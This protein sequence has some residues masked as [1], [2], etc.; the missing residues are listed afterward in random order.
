MYI[1]GSSWN[2]CLDGGGFIPIE[3][4]FNCVNNSCLP[5]NNLIAN[6]VTTTSA[7]LSL[8]ACGT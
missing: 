1:N 5:V 6:N 4:T 2:C 8:T 7:D 3:A